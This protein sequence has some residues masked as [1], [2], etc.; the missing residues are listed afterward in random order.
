VLHRSEAPIGFEPS[1]QHP[2]YFL[3]SSL[4]SFIDSVPH[5]SLA[6]LGGGVP[7]QGDLYLSTEVGLALPVR[8]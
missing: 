2:H 5:G 4:G 3:V 1:V 6:K 8:F 7:F